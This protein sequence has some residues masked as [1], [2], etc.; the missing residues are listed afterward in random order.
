MNQRTR[1]VAALQSP[2]SRNRQSPKTLKRMQAFQKQAACSNCSR[3]CE[4][5]Q[6]DAAAPSATAGSPSSI[7]V[8]DWDTLFCAIQTK[9]MLTIEGLR[10]APPECPINE[11]A[12]RV[13]VTVQE[14]VAAMDLLHSA[15]NQERGLNG[16]P[17]DQEALFYAQ[18]LQG[19]SPPRFEQ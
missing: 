4:L 16:V 13:R 1:P 18:W 10:E 7:E 9:L 15:L 11:A 8:G 6:L 3:P 14:C 5:D 2:A 12:L 19:C 17:K